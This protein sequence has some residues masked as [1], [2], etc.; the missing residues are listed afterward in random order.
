MCKACACGG[1]E[2][3]LEGTD[4]N[5][6]TPNTSLLTAQGHTAAPSINIVS[7]HEAFVH[8]TLTLPLNSQS[9]ASA[10]ELLPP[11]PTRSFFAR[12][13][14]SVPPE[15][16]PL[17]KEQQVRGFCVFLWQETGMQSQAVR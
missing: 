8:F 15:L 3:E 7:Y 10:E 9:R 12:L 16:K 11:P 4:T 5:T 17:Y 1:C 13:F 14:C 2:K 6:Q